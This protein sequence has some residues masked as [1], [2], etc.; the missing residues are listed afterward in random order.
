VHNRIRT[1]AADAEGRQ[2]L[3][4]YMIR[5]PFAL[6]KMSYEQRSDMVSYRS[7]MRAMLKRNYQLM[8]AWKCEAVSS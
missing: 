5:C 6:N 8:L 3:A 1:K 7:R 2:G 4:R